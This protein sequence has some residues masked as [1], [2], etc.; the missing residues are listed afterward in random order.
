[1][2]GAT[3]ADVAARNLLGLAVPGVIEIVEMAMIWCTFAGI[4]AAFAA[5]GHITVDLVDTLA[6]QRAARA[7]RLAAALA[8]VAGMA[9]LTALAVRELTDALEW[10]D[11]TVVLGLPHSAFWVAIAA[12]YGCG[13]FAALAAVRTR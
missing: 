8:T 12:G 1:M 10:G 6:P 5:G 13:A 3:V 2:M 4:A 11:T 7:V 9:G